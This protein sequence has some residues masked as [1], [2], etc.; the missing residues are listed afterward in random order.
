MVEEIKEKKQATSKHHRKL[1]VMFALLLIAVGGILIYRSYSRQKDFGNP[2]ASASTYTLP[3]SHPKHIKIAAIKVDADIVDLGLNPDKTLEVPKQ[4]SKVGWYTQSPTP[5]ELGPSIMVGHLDSSTSPAVFY[6]LKDLKQGDRIEV[7]REDGTTATFQV[8]SMKSVEQNNFP[9]QEVYGDIA[10]AGLRLITC[11]GTYLRSEG[12][13]QNN[14][15]VYASLVKPDQ[16][17]SK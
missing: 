7:T 15:I 11:D 17:S 3:K 4:Y 12:H 2:N 10:F 8:D 16:V 14:L 1:T 13:Y 9:T 6:K 5:G